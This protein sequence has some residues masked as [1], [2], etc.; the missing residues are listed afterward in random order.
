MRER[1][2][3][4]DEVCIEKTKQVSDGEE[5]ER[6]DQRRRDSQPLFFLA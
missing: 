6:R 4:V 5:R 2:G 1:F 3:D